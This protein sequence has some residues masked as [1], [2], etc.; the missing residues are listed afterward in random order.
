[1]RLRYSREHILNEYKW[2]KFYMGTPCGGDSM[3]RRSKQ[4][5]EACLVACESV[6]VCL[7]CL[8]GVFMTVGDF[9]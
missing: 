2:K 4:C 5:S 9:I 8:F 7:F 1:M 3:A 6:T